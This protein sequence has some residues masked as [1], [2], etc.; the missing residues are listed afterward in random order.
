[1]MSKELEAFDTLLELAK[2]LLVLAVDINGNFEYYNYD[3]YVENCE[4]YGIKPISKDKYNK[5]LEVIEDIYEEE[6]ENE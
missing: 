5:L 1:M 4:Y 3:D 2:P 6:Q